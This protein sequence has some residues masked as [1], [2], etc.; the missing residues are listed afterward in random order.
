MVV[1]KCGECEAALTASV[2]KLTDSSVLVNPWVT[3]LEEYA[4]EDY[5]P[6]GSYT[7]ATSDENPVRTTLGS[8]Y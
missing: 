5:L 3:S 2:S 7:V 8:S 6:V 4:G 1:F